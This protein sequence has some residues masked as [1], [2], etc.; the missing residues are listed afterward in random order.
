[1]AGYIYCMKNDHWRYGKYVKIGY[2]ER[3]PESRRV[4]LSTKWRSNFEILWDLDVYESARAES[5]L[6]EVLST[7]RVEYEFFRIDPER[8]KRLAEDFFD[9]RWREIEGKEILP[10]SLDELA[11]R[12]ARGILLEPE[13]SQYDPDLGP[14][15]D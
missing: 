5:F 7:F 10:P 12:D 4:E 13:Q 11:N 8:A 2:T 6:H 3:S 15:T 9:E 1:M 14:D